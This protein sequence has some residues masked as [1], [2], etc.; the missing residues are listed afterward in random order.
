[1]PEHSASEDQVA[2]GKLKRYT[3]PGVEPAEIIQTG[4]ETL[5]SDIYKLIMLIWNKEKLPHQR[6]KSIMVPI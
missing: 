1:V 2:V 4:G 5:C 3:P 6:K